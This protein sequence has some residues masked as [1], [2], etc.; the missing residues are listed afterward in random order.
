MLSS[1]IS[2]NVQVIFMKDNFE[3]LIKIFYLSNIKI[4]IGTG[5]TIKKKVAMLN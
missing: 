4:V 1:D 3:T 2:G 5:T